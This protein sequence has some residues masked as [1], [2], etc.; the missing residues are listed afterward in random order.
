MDDDSDYGGR[1]ELDDL[2]DQLDELVEST[3]QLKVSL[4]AY[5]FKCDTSLAM[6]N[7]MMEEVPLSDIKIYQQIGGAWV[8]EVKYHG[9]LFVHINGKTKPEAWTEF[10]G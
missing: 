7:L 1:D 10:S 2:Y 5:E 3:K 8:S 4:N 9:I 6:I